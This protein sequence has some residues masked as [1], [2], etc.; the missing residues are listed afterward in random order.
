MAMTYIKVTCDI[1][2]NQYLS[3]DWT[4]HSLLPQILVLAKLH[5]ETQDTFSPNPG[6]KLHLK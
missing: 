2:M 1:E 3:Q 4:W 6:F 5:Y